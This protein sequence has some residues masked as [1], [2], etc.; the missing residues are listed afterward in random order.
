[1]GIRHLDVPKT[2]RYLSKNGMY[3]RG[4][5]YVQR[6]YVYRLHIYDT[7]TEFGIKTLQVFIGRES[8]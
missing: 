4:Y 2:N 8:S 3:R 1:M 6:V 5:L 7:G